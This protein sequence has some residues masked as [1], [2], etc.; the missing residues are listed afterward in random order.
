MTTHPFAPRP[1]AAFLAVCFCLFS[2]NTI[3]KWIDQD[4][5]RFLLPRSSLC[6]LSSYSL[7]SPVSQRCHCSDFYCIDEFCLF[8]SFVQ[9]ESF[10]IFYFCVWPLSCSMLSLRF[11]HAVFS[12]SFFFLCNSATLFL[13]ILLLVISIWVI[14]SCHLIM[15]NRASMNI[16]EPFL[17]GVCIPWAP[18]S[19]SRPD[20]SL[21]PTCF[22]PACVCPSFIV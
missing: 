21:A 10:S 13:S 17:L 6:S 1:E 2:S 4:V 16:L 14:I 12:N 5:E 3:E 8:L 9:M 22:S 19:G 11:I 20:K 15:M 7:Q 18:F